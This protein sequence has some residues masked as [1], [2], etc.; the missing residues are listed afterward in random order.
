M[1]QPPPAA[2]LHPIRLGSLHPRSIPWSET[3]GQAFYPEYS[4]GQPVSAA[5]SAKIKA[6]RLKPVPLK[7][8]MEKR[9][10]E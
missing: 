4:E 5:A 9:E 10:S 8:L 7:F 6:D 1:Q 2:N 3:A